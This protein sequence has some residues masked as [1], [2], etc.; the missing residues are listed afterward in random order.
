MEKRIVRKNTASFDVDAQKGFTPLCPDELPVAGGDGIAA[1]L[2][3]QA[4]YAR[5]RV[6]SKD[7]HCRQAI[8][9]ASPAHPQFSPLGADNADIYWNS[10]CVPGTPGFELIP[11]LPR[12]IEYDFFV[13]KGIEPD[14]HPY[15]ACYHDLA[16]RK[17]TGVIEYL[18]TRGID[19][20][21]CGGLATD[22][23]VLNT[24]LQLFAGGFRVIVN[25]SAC[26]GVAES[27]SDE[28]VQRMRDAGIQVV[29]TLEGFELS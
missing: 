25:L 2:N 3:E 23:C 29:D 15:G 12:P 26:R 28:A 11:G 18:K 16:E 9:T 4:G 20:V 7:A 8:Y 17:S 27:T 21:I 14:L 13:W 5:L 1:A 6:G 19:T 10:H 24:A 22:Y